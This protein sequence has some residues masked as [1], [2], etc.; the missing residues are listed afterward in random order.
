MRALALPL[1]LCLAFAV[2]A[3]AQAARFIKVDIVSKSGKLGHHHAE[4]KVEGPTEVKMRMP[5]SLAK[6]VLEMAG[7]SEIK[8]NGE[9]KHGLKPDA[10][11]KLLETS[12]PGDLLLEITTNNGDHIRIVLE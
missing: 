1:T 6:S 2:P 3:T 8:V 10:L 4:K 11:I 12:K 9:H 5:I 7:Q